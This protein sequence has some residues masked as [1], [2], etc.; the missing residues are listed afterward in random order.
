VKKKLFSN[1]LPQPLSATSLS[2]QPQAAD[3][4]WL[5]VSSAVLCLIFIIVFVRLLVVWNKQSDSQQLALRPVTSSTIGTEQAVLPF[6]QNVASGTVA[7]ENT[8]LQADQLVF[9][10]IYQAPTTSWSIAIIA[11]QAQAPQLPLNIKNETANYYEVRR[12]YN[13][14][15]L[16][17]KLN[18]QGLVLVD[19]PFGSATQDFFS[20]Y[21][22]AQQDKWPLILTN[23]VIFYYY[24]NNLKEVYKTLEAGFYDGL[25]QVSYNLFNLANRR[26]QAASSKTVTTNDPLIEAYRLNV[27]YWA[28]CLQLMAPQDSQINDDGLAES[29]IAF[30]SGDDQIYKLPN[31]AGDLSR[32]VEQEV[33]LIKTAK[34]KDISPLFGQTFDYSFFQPDASYQS[35]GR[36]ANF[37]LASQ[38]LSRSWPV[39]YRGVNCPDCQL[40]IDDWR[41]NFL[42]ANVLSA[43][44]AGN[45]ESKN[46][47]AKVYKVISYFAGLRDDLT[48]IH[49]AQAQKEVF[50]DQSLEQVMSL[51]QQGQNEFLNKLQTAILKNN[52]SAI[53]GGWDRSRLENRPNIGLR[54]L[55]DHYWPG[56]T[57]DWTKIS[58]TLDTYIN[59]Q[60]VKDWHTNQFWSSLSLLKDWLAK[61]L[62]IDKSWWRPTWWRSQQLALA[63]FYLIN[64]QLQADRLAPVLPDSGLIK[65]SGMPESLVS[66]DTSG[67]AAIDRQMA[68]AKMLRLA[69]AQLRAGNLLSEQ[70]LGETIDTLQTIRDLAVKQSNGQAWT[71]DETALVN[72]FFE[73]NLAQAGRK[74][75]SLK[76]GKNEMSWQRLQARLEI[77]TVNGQPHIFIGPVIM[78]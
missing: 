23:D 29:T 42:A 78:P 27:Q 49:Y 15:P 13:L 69:L 71:T 4:N 24:Q 37:A 77:R 64:W 62:I 63:Q 72:N 73:R 21:R 20:F 28:V 46:Y 18:K 2:R 48:Y 5:W 53:D 22:A 55:Q 11:N 19:N 6:G 45:Q 10:R 39:Y 41:V 30:R 16:V 38:W 76:P 66:I 57:V 47:W 75:I 52:F 36:L 58:S 17:D 7:G 50:N 65:D 33:A 9:S 3:G 54:V 32:E 31:L 51:D 43:D 34:A 61:S 68:T 26:Y 70:K 40:D 60:Q 14:E 67:L 25:W 44:L 8:N 74:T 35:G 12:H 56:Q 1:S 59:Q